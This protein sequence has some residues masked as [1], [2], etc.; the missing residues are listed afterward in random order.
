MKSILLVED[1]KFFASMVLR[2][3]YQEMDVNVEWAETYADAVRLMDRRPDDFFISLLDLTLPDAPS[4][5]IVD[6]AVAK[7]IPVV[8][9]TSNL[10]D[11]IREGILS[12]NVV[13]Y[14]LKENTASLD[15]VIANIKRIHGNSG[16]KILV[17]DDSTTS[18]KYVADLLR[19][20]KYDILEAKN[21]LEA[22]DVLEA[23]PDLKMLIT[24]YNMPEMDGFSL[25]REVRKRH[26]RERL[27]IIGLSAYGNNILSAR[28]IKN[29]A[30]D[31]I[32]KPFLSEE[33]YCRVQ[34]N[35]EMLEYIDKIRDVAI[36][37]YL[38]GLYNRRYFFETARKTHAESRRQGF[39]LGIAMIDLDDFKQIN[40]TY[41]HD[42]GD[43][44]L[45]RVAGLL[46]ARF[47]E[48]DIVAR[49]GGEEFCVLTAYMDRDRAFA[50]FDA[51]RAEIEALEIRTPDNDLARVTVSIGLCL[52]R[53]G[54]IDEMVNRADELLYSVKRTG[55][56]KVYVC[57]A[58]AVH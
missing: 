49:L 55:K 9:F 39:E 46:K 34:Q 53:L 52:D 14:V 36:K 3:I 17:V 18:R 51:L 31:F 29:G 40:D 44:V 7:G 20:Q 33:F 8:V 26:S 16:I 38:T 21:G 35:I 54:S 13:D 48:S 4:G 32:N 27:A 28:F 30:N 50:V 11:D 45:A 2:R 24:D 42:L 12:K 1:S 47:R 6:Y 10:D 43:K 58:P 37:D 23:N 15:A 57:A 19:V 41:G 56:N 5:E 25:I 22:L